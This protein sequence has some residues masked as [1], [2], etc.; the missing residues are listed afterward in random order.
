MSR[1]A[2]L[3]ALLALGGCGF[4][5]VY[6]PDG[7]GAERAPGAVPPAT[8]LQ[9]AS[10]RVGPM[11]ERTGQQFRRFLQR[12]LE[13]RV[14]GTP[15]RYV[16]TVS[17]VQ[18]VEAI[19]FRQDGTITRIRFVVNA[20]WVLSTEGDEPE[21]VE[22]GRARTLDSFNIPDLQFYAAE[23]SGEGMQTRL[24]EELAEQVVQGVAIALSR[25]PGA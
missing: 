14:P 1:R 7:G 20:D 8:A 25:R 18:E 13:G 19:G 17:I 22:R 2:L 3:G 24:R 21:V 6:G 16:L 4:R 5:P 23:I 9:L 10:V 15:S 12:R 11:V